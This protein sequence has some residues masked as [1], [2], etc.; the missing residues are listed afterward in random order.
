M[1]TKLTL[2]SV[3]FAAAFVPSA[4]IADDPQHKHDDTATTT[5]TDPDKTDTTK[6]DTTDAAVSDTELAALAHFR[7]VNQMEIDMGK[8]AQKQS[9]NKRV[10]AFGKTLVTDHTRALK[11]ADAFIKANKLTLPADQPK[12]EAA[13]QQAEADMREMDRVKTLSGVEFDRAFLT[14]MAEGYT[15]ELSKLDEAIAA[16]SNAKL[17]AIFEKARPS[18]AKHAEVASK[19]DTQVNQ[20]ASAQ[21]TTAPANKDAQKDKTTTPQ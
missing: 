4:A 7:H 12:D 20:T 21:G 16:T 11:Q 5:K 10:K 2:C 18:M 17:K 15:R 14:M 8:L 19:L 9:K 1:K 6:P 13:Q 3:L